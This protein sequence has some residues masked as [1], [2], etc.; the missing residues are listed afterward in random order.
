MLLFTLF[1]YLYKSPHPLLRESTNF[2][3][4][5]LMVESW[6]MRELN[7]VRPNASLS[8]SYVTKTIMNTLGVFM[9]ILY[10]NSE[11]M[12][13]L[14]KFVQ[15]LPLTYFKVYLLK[16]FIEAVEAIDTEMGYMRFRT[17]VYN[18]QDNVMPMIC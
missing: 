15:E 14:I 7:F 12:S 6:Q 11:T 18:F 13:D 17:M 10:E 9:K 5:M 16:I 2:Y 4:L 8:Q 3:R 1:S